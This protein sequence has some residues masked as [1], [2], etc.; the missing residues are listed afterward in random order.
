M[1]G[2]CRVVFNCICCV[3]GDFVLSSVECFAS[4]LL[5]VELVG[6]SVRWNDAIAPLCFSDLNSFNTDGTLWIRQCRAAVTVAVCAR[7][8]PG[9][10]SLLSKQQ[11]DA[12]LL[13][14]ASRLGYNSPALDY[15]ASS[16]V[17]WD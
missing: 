7:V 17:R 10:Q 2:Y 4:A 15:F 6:R 9:C 16:P 8:P 13:D 12:L 11:Y 1:P 3:E 5:S 14:P